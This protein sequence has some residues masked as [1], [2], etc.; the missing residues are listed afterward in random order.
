MRPKCPAWV[1]IDS[2]ISLLTISSSDIDNVEMSLYDI[3]IDLSFAVHSLTAAMGI[4]SHQAIIYAW[5]SRE[6]TFI[7]N[8][9]PFYSQSRIITTAD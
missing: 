5:V 4:Y 7:N 3:I 6:K 8:S 2:V 1:V 9:I